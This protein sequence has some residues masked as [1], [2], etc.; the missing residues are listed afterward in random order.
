M[1]RVFTL[2]AMLIA[3]S[4]QAQVS[5]PSFEIPGFPVVIDGTG[6][7]NGWFHSAGNPLVSNEVLGYQSE[8]AAKLASSDQA[9]NGIVGSTNFTPGNT[10][11]VSFYVRTPKCQP[12]Q[13]AVYAAN[14][15]KPGSTGASQSQLITNYGATTGGSWQLVQVTFSPRFCFDQIHFLL[16]GRE[17]PAIMYIDEVDVECIPGDNIVP[18]H[19]FEDNTGSDFGSG[20]VTDW[21]TSHYTPT[22]FGGGGNNWAWMW[23]YSGDG[24]GILA[25]ATFNAGVT[26]E[27]S[28]RVRTNTPPNAANFFLVA[29]NGITPSTAWG[30]PPAGVPQQ[31]IDSDA[32]GGV[33]TTW[34]TV[35]TTFT[36]TNNYSQL[37]IYPLMAGGPTGGVQAELEIDD[38][39]IRRACRRPCF[40]EVTIDP[41]ELPG[42]LQGRGE[43]TRTVEPADVQALGLSNE[44]MVPVQVYP[45]PV[46]DAVTMEILRPA[47]QQRIVRILSLQ[48]EEVAQLKVAQGQTK[49][50]WKVPAGLQNGMYFMAI[51]GQNAAAP[52]LIQ[53]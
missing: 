7:V 8:H 43:P 12:G 34:Q 24:E 32:M 16:D 53:K 41:I 9:R 26:Y 36:A 28:Y 33:Y 45:N 20:D 2:M 14:G 22:L 25:N 23:S 39:V 11:L 31:T 1:K 13:L 46:R 21:Q 19:D 50:E 38:I 37:M 35:T 47:A 6:A 48:G 42:K 15:M 44:R 5:N 27:V 51:D 10:Y 49:V 3:I 52:I 29:T 17:C 30:A 4:T 18:N 40:V